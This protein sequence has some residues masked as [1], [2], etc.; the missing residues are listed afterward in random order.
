VQSCIAGG[1]PVKAYLHWSLLDNFE[2]MMG[3]EPKFGLI[4]VDRHTQKRTPKES[5]NC[6]GSFATAKPFAPAK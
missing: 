3:F 4:A 5:L 1:I 6:L 2:W